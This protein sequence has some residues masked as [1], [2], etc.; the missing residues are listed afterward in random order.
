MRLPS[1]ASIH[2]MS[3]STSTI[4]RHALPML[5]TGWIGFGIWALAVLLFATEWYFYDTTRHTASPYAYYLGWSCFIWALA[6]LVL[7]FAG[8]HPIQRQEWQRAVAIHAGAGVAFSIIQACVEGSIGWL[9]MV[10][11]LS[12]G[13]TLVHYLRQHA[14]L[15]LLT[16]W[17]L[18]AAAQFYRIHSEAHER[19]L[20][21]AQLEMQLLRSQLQPHFLFN[22]LHAAVALVQEDPAAAEDVLLRL[23]ELLRASLMDFQT[24][25]V[26]LRREMQFLDCYLG[27]QQR[28]FGERLRTEV[29]VDPLALDI[30]VPSLIL[31]PLVEN[32]IRHG[33]GAHK[34]NDVVRVSI[35][36]DAANLVLEVSNGNSV[37]AEPPDRLLRRGVG[38]ANTQARVRQL[39]GEQH[40]LELYNLEPRGVLVRLMLPARSRSPQR[41]TI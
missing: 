14:Q 15:Y 19:R 8:Q 5:R 27:I 33:V 26:P 1:I 11:G 21:A 4:G 20:R 2:H 16:Y 24:N 3:E 38:L 25:E 34:G 10:H 41:E 9:R 30:V 40:C 36:R 18:V 6:P 39:Y 37:L 22:T 28:R 17:T 12:Y 31:Q 32:A 23:S 35:F 29:R 13:A 7:R